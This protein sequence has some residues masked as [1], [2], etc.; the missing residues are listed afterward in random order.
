M[1]KLTALLLALLTLA[2]ALSGCTGSEPVTTI[3]ATEKATEADTVTVQVTEEE[4]EPATEE[5]ITA[6]DDD[7]KISAWYVN[8]FTKTSPNNPAPTDNKSFTV[9]MT[10]G[11]C[12]DAQIVISSSENREG[13]SVQAS[14]LK[15]RKGDEIQTEVLRQYYVKCARTYYPDPVAPMNDT[16][17]CFDLKAGRSQAMFI[18]LKTTAE[19]PA[20]DYAGVVSVMQGDKTVKQLRLFCHVWDIV[21]PETMTSVAT[22]NLYRDQIARFH[23]MSAKDYYKEYYEFLLD[24][25]VNPWDMPYDIL[26]ERSEVYMNDPRVNSFSIPYE[27]NDT[28]LLSARAQ[29]I[30]SNELWV[31]KAFYYPYDEPTDTDKLNIVAGVGTTIKKYH[32]GARIVVP[33]FTDIEYDGERDQ[34]A[35]MSEYIN[36]WC[37]KTF[38]FTKTTDKAT[39]KRVLYTANQRKKYTEFGQRMKDEVAGGD[40]VW[41]YVCWE[42]GKPY[43]NMFI[44]MQGYINRLLFWQQKQYDCTGFLY[45]SSNAW[46]R[47]KNPWTNMATVG[48]DYRTGASGL[49][50]GVFGDGSLLYPGSEVNVD[51]PCGSVRLHA[52]RD[53]LEEYEMLTMLEQA[54]GRDAVDAIIAKVSTNIIEYTKNENDLADARIELGNAL[55][56]ALKNK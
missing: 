52:V 47:V 14:T 22:V 13:L 50:D 24:F 44:D 10:R 3:P 8:S 1:K 11:E 49:S 25:R 20:G 19:T 48:T 53:G 51:G 28:N 32:P 54:A 21:M 35:M 37:P 12:E 23:D 4:T 16:T 17:R 29:K 7:D 43:A 9:Y 36:I 45:W 18:Q 46:D 2:A 38:C 34:I 30:T 26:D 41:W 42:P 55:E 33:F 27:W 40:E 15:N 39:G 5:L 31:K 56:A 6:P